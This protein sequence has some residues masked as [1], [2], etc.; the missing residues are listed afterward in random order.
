MP[1]KG[2]APLSRLFWNS[3]RR[4][5]CEFALFCPTQVNKWVS[6]G[7]KAPPNAN[8]LIV[9]ILFLRLSHNRRFSI[10]NCFFS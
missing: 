4:M 5:M 7:Q 9:G 3:K 8:G 1:K 6:G 2:V 10:S